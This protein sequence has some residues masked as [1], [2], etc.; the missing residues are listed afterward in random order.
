MRR[1]S[2]LPTR[3]GSEVFGLRVLVNLRSER[4]RIW[5]WWWWCRWAWTWSLYS[6]YSIDDDNRQCELELGDGRECLRL[7]LHTVMGSTSQTFL[8]P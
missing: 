7:T 1:H 5:W 3:K 2:P 8:E 6:L 4:K